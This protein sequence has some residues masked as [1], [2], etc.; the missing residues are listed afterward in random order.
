MRASLVLCLFLT[1]A[2]PLNAAPDTAGVEFFEKKIRPVLAEHCYKCHSAR[3]HRGGLALDS[4]D[5]VRKGGDS[6]PA[7]V[8][9]KP[10]ASL[11]LKAIRHVD[12]KMPPDGKLP[13]AIVADFRAWIEM[14][15]PD[16]RDRAG[17]AVAATWDEALRTRRQWW[18]LQPV[19]KP[20]LPAVRDG[21]WAANPVDRFLLARLE[22][23]ALAPPTP[24]DRRTRIRRLS[25][26]LTGLA[27]RPEE[28]EAFVADESPAAYEKVVDRVLAS[29]HYGERWARHWMD[30]VRYAETHGFEWNYEVHHAW[31]YRDYL[32]RAFNEDLPYDQLVREHIAGDLLPRPRRHRAGRFNESA[33]GTAF[34]RFGEVGHD[35]CVEFRAIALDALDNQIDT[36]SKAF[37]AT[38]VACARCHDHK[39]DAVSMKDYYALLGVLRSSR[40]VSHTIDDPQVNAE[41]M[42]ELRALKAAIRAEVGRAWLDETRAADRYLL[43]ALA[44]QSGETQGLDVER[45]RRWTAALKTAAVPDDPLHAWKVATAPTTADETFAGR[46]RR[47][48]AEWERE[49]RARADFN[50]KNFVPFGDFRTG[51]LEG[52]RADGQGL[53]GGPAPSGDF[54][55]AGTGDAAVTAIFPAGV[56][57]HGLSER[58]NGALRSPLLPAGKKYLSLRVLGGKGGAA[59]LV[60]DGCQLNY[61]HFKYLTGDRAG[62]VQLTLNTGRLDLRQYAELMTKLDN[63]KF[64]DQLGTLSGGATS[65]IPYEQAVADPR[66]CFGVTRA[67]LHDLAESPRDERTHL[68]PLFAGPEPGSAAEL[69]G[70]Y[71]AVLEAAVRAWAAG[72]ASDEDVAWIDWLLQRGLLSNSRKLTPRLQQLI[73]RYR[74]VEQRL[75]APRVVPGLADFE[76]G[77]AQPIYARGDF[78]KPGETVARRYLEV[79]AG[80]RGAFT[81]RGSGRL[82]LAESLASPDNPL[83]ARVMVNR[84]WHH[85]FGAGLVRTVDDFGHMGERPLHPELLDYLAA[86]FVEDGWSVKRLVRLLVLTRAFQASNRFTAEAR[87]VDPENRLLHRYPARRMEAEALRDA[88]LAASGRLERRLYGLSVSPYREKPNP[89]RRLFPGPLDGH[90][91][92]SI[93]VK[94]TLM[95]GP[96]FLVAF[97]FPGGKVTRGRRDVTN[98]PAQALA[99]LNDPLVLQQAEFWA[100]HLV[101]TPDAS[102]GAR[103]ERM[104]LLALGRPPEADER[105]QF[106]Q[107]ID[108]LAEGYGVR[109]G[110][111]LRSREVWKDVAHALFNVKEFTYIP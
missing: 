40:Q 94:P 64:P 72:R 61:H 95:E 1:A 99:L 57:T 41:P 53:R 8:P 17:P 9:G 4:R 43:A 102:V 30:V 13:D 98:V 35:D 47:L 73:E 106:V 7:V 69:A 85:L 60:T 38:T 92:R 19:R 75:A 89:D 68:R 79:L 22:K 62:W 42:Q 77:F 55:V 110:E 16:P 56:F 39:L 108:R 29:P 51:S 46:W 66:S 82:E 27:P 36:L 49:A 78:S 105:T 23:A 100:G 11:L 63:P 6:G 59:R 87:R 50:A 93:Y 84:V 52:W 32:I 44:R 101:A 67:V 48:G 12:L 71:A 109:P 91:R 10:A 80:G 5:G 81:A 103:V 24:A 14:G 88:I 65:R 15:A 58:L 96:S 34:F 33:I 74:A 2:P 31:R 3:K 90:G 26:V 37:Q 83:T 70:R 107:A 25:L 97:N 104:F 45:L 20:A 76:E 111:V 28:V 86:R 18:S 54:A 21:A